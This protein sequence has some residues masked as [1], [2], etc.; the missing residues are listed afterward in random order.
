[1]PH[2]TYYGYFSIKSDRT[3]ISFHNGIKLQNI[4]QRHYISTLIFKHHTTSTLIKHGYFPIKS[5][6]IKDNPRMSKQEPMHLTRPSH[7]STTRQ[8]RV[9]KHGHS[10]TVFLMHVYLSHTTL[11]IVQKP[12]DALS[13]PL[14][15]II[16]LYVT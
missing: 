2:H 6:R 1:M 9:L 3:Y 13:D 5:D 10:A 14:S 4:C 7:R 8:G 15:T 16:T 12:R 11:G